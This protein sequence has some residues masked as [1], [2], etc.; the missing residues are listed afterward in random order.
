MLYVLYIVLGVLIILSVN[1][2]VTACL[3]LKDVY[4]HKNENKLGFAQSF[5]KY[6]AKNNN[7]S[8]KISD[9]FN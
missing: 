3:A 7:L 8:L 6:F 2:A 9:F 5:R 4:Q 1:L